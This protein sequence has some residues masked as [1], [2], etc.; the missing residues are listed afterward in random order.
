VVQT[1][2][3][4]TAVAKLYVAGA[5]LEPDDLNG[6]VLAVAKQILAAQTR[7]YVEY[8]VPGSDARPLEHVEMETLHRAA[9]S[10]NPWTSGCLS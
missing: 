9:E 8:P 1:Q 7:A 4:R 3:A 10:E 2:L 5:R 6:A